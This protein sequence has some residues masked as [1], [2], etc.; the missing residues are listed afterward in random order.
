[1]DSQKTPRTLLLALLIVNAISTILHYMDNF[2]F[3]EQ[4][5]QPAWITPD[6]IYIAWIALTIFGIF[7][8]VF[9]ARNAF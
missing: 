3:Y 4:Y 2:V 1:M 6:S 5:P 8:Y 9:Y 7:G